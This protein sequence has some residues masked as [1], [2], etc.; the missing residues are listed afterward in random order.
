MSTVLSNWVISPLYK[1]VISPISR[2]PVGTYTS[3]MDGMGCLN[4]VS[5][6]PY[7]TFRKG[8]EAGYGQ[9]IYQGSIHFIKATMVFRTWSLGFDKW[10]TIPLGFFWVCL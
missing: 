5:P 8:A 1:E 3:P 2:C 6:E 4:I 9:S 10:K 7:Q